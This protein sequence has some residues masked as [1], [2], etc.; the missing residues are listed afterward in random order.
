MAVYTYYAFTLVNGDVITELPLSGVAPTW[1]VNDP[2]DLGSPTLYLG[3]LSNIQRADMRAATVPY[4]TGIAVDRDGVIIWSGVVTARRYDSGTKKFAISC[5]GLLAYWRRRF[6]DANLTYTAVDQF[7]IVAGLLRYGGTPTVPVIMQYGASGMRR[8][9]TVSGTDQKE[10]LAEILEIAD[11]LNGFELAIDTSWDAAQRTQG[12]VHYLRIGSPRLGNVADRT[13][14]VLT[15]EYPGNARSYTWDEDGEQFA[16]Q[17]YGSSTDQDGVVTTDGA[18][19]TTLIANGFPQVGATRQW[20]NITNTDTL[21]DHIVQ[22]L[23]EG[24]GY[25]DAPVFMVRDEGDTAAGSFVAG[26]DVRVR[27]TDDARFPRPEGYMG[28][29]IDQTVRISKA[30]LDPVAGTIAMEMFG[31]T[32]AVQ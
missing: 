4:K 27:I 18:Q 20:S 9:R 23:T 7:D 15:L 30:T 22:A 17:I 10:A 16:T 11:N 6:I 26:D 28:P 29:G 31:F 25:Q 1:Q 2:G 12:F 24:N 13:G 5:P 8:D 32:E 14:A 21:R 3:D 19:N